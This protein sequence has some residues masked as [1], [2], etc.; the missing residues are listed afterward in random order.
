MGE[1]A[2]K[3]SVRLS[4]L[5][6]NAGLLI[7]LRWSTVEGFLDWAEA[8]VNSANTLN[9]FVKSNRQAS[10][11]ISDVDSIAITSNPQQSKPGASTHNLSSRSTTK[12]PLLGPSKDSMSAH[13]GGG[14]GPVSKAVP[15]TAIPHKA[16]RTE[17]AAPLRR[18]TRQSAGNSESV[19]QPPGDADEV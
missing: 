5:I 8:Q 2:Y 9:R 18:S 12:R 13:Q 11:T 10:V 16:A 1:S 3:N 15:N 6:I 7:N 4:Q 17:L 19:T 14:Q